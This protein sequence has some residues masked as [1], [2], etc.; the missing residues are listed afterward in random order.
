MKEAHRAHSDIAARNQPSNL[1]WLK[2]AWLEDM[3]T[4][5]VAV[6]YVDG[7][8][9]AVN[10][11]L[12]AVDQ[13]TNSKL[14]A[15]ITHLLGYEGHAY[16]LVWEDGLETL[17]QTLALLPKLFRYCDVGIDLCVR[18]KDTLEGKVPE[19]PDYLAANQSLKNLVRK[20]DGAAGP[21]MDGHP[22]SINEDSNQQQLQSKAAASTTK[23][24]I[25][26][27]FATRMTARAD[28]WAQS[29]TDAARNIGGWMASAAQQLGK[30]D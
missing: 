15:P 21:S 10:F 8:Q 6:W 17:G 20:L 14:D 16:Q 1:Y 28:T 9:L 30:Q 19:V 3:G 27:N 26:A 24:S 4:D 25:N 18:F 5:T 22:P 13:H 23:W 7:D 2:D 29:I 12:L 11:F